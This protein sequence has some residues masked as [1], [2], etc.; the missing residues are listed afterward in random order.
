MAYIFDASKGETPES[1]AYKRAIAARLMG[2]IGN[3]GANSVGEGIGNALSSL[4]AGFAA[5]GWNKNAD[6]SEKTGRGE[7]TS[8]FDQIRSGITSRSPVRSSAPSGPMIPYDPAI[9]GA[10]GAESHGATIRDGLTQRG[11]PEH[12]ADGFVMNFKDESGLDPS[13]NEQNPLVPGSRGG[14]GLAQWTGPRRQALEAYAQSRGLPASDQNVQLDFLKTELEGPEASA[15][16]SI[17][18]TENTGD[19]AAAIAQDFLR[20]APQHLANR[21]ASYRSQPEADMA[22][23]PGAQPVQ[24][25]ST[26]P[27]SGPSMEQLMQLSAS[28][29]LND[30][31]R[32][33]VNTLLKQQ[34]E[35]NDPMRALQM[36]KLRG[37]IAEGNSS[38]E[39]FYGNPMA[40]QNPD[41]STS[42]GQMGNRG[43]FRPI[44]LPEGQK[45]APPT[46]KVDTGTEVLFMDQAGNVIARTP[47]D[48][49]GAEAAKVEGK[50]VGE[51]KALLD[52]MNSKM[53]GLQQ[54]V[55]KLDDLAG[56]A[57][58]TMA[59]Q[60]LDAGRRQ[61]D[62]EPRESAVARSEYTS[63]VDNQILPLLRDTFGA[64]FTQKEGDTLRAT[65]GDPDKSP[66]EKQALLRAFIEQKQRDIQALSVRTG[67]QPAPAAD[68]KPRLK[69]NPATGDFE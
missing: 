51:A 21:V 9:Y 10:E 45:F 30:G 44:E 12:V 23:L 15:G 58:Y 3:R 22:S 48:L 6:A 26:M 47:K 57:T 27:G 17:M 59:G 50:D 19:A 28:P 54:V 43:T 35:Q 53:P 1:V 39:T 34:M 20:P 69:F 8:M 7:A 37:E 18:A 49:A 40:I 14:F 63:I 33:V 4:G 31:Q 52:S 61:M 42:F 29:W 41:G 2:G 46:K 68:A 66:Q 24:N 38:N 64:Q 16:Q 60:A 55:T 25:T 62:M 11:L 5:R 56:K 32:A 13:I 65:L 67:Q 36:Q